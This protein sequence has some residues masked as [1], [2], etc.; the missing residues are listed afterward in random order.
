[1]KRG[2]FACRR[3][4][5]PPP[6]QPPS[7]L[8]LSLSLSVCLSAPTTIRQHRQQLTV[9]QVKHAPLHPHAVVAPRVLRRRV[10]ILQ[11]GADDAPD[12]VAA[13]EVPPGRALGQ[14]AHGG[15]QQRPARL[16]Q[17][18]RREAA[19]QQA[20]R[21]A[22]D[23]RAAVDGDEAALPACGGG[24]RVGERQ[25]E[26]P[27]AVAQ[28]GVAHEAKAAEDA[29]GRRRLAVPVLDGVVVGADGR[30]G[31]LAAHRRSLVG[32][33]DGKAR[34]R[35]G[36]GVALDAREAL[37]FRR[38]AG[39]ARA[40]RVMCKRRVRMRIVRGR[41]GGGARLQRGLFTRLLSRLVGIQHQAVAPSTKK[42]HTPRL[43]PHRR[44]SE[45][46]AYIALHRPRRPLAAF[47]AHT[48]RERRANLKRNSWGLLPLS[49][50]S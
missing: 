17:V 45:P 39:P 29:V 12:G 36:Q 28:V 27:L 44:S 31:R 13:R 43:F 19:Q 37:C 18:D 34:A 15:V 40:S 6:P 10:E 23:A 20:A 16:E 3:R 48:K 14:V 24:E 26:Q 1:M 21:D 46:T 42:S 2:C 4:A 32:R 11:P 38:I 41:C 30:G 9:R 50:G 47:P 33:V 35:P 7:P 49:Q 5:S 22:P 25:G 8:S